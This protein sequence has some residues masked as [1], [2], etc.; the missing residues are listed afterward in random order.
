MKLYWIFYNILLTLLKVQP[1]FANHTLSKKSN[2]LFMLSLKKENSI[3][4]IIHST[5][6][7]L[8]VELP[9]KIEHNFIKKYPTCFSRKD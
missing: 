5:N 9:H 3:V 8:L 7:E 6:E 4:L 1:L 2:S